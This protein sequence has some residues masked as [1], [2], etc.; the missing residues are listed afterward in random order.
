MHKKKTL[1]FLFVLLLA[2][3][4]F[5]LSL[6]LFEKENTLMHA[7][8]GYLRIPFFSATHWVPLTSRP[9]TIRQGAPL[10]WANNS[11]FKA[12]SRRSPWRSI[13]SHVLTLRS[14][15]HP[16]SLSQSKRSTA[17]RKRVGRVKRSTRERERE[18]CYLFI[19]CSL[20]RIPLNTLDKLE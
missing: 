16:S 1:E 10:F 4:S 14:F 18:K 7:F 17:E 13:K 15:P 19:P 3:F 12:R 6:C 8:V 20:A 2:A 9:D 5:S 11:D